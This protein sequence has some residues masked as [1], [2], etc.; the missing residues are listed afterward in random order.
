VLNDYIRH[1]STFP[2]IML[3]TGG[4]HVDSRSG[5]ERS[6]SQ[7]GYRAEQYPW[8]QVKRENRAER[9][10]ERVAAQDLGALWAL[11][12]HHQQLQGKRSPRTLT[13]YKASARAYLSWAFRQSAGLLLA[14][15]PDTGSAYLRHLEAR[16]LAPASVNA[17]RAA[18]VA[19]YRALRWT[20]ATDADPYRDTRGVRDP[21]PR[22]E[23]RAPYTLSELRVLLDAGTPTERAMLLLMGLCGLRLS[24]TAALC[25]LDVDFNAGVLTVVN[26]KGGKRARV[27]VPPQ[28]AAVLQ[29]LGPSTG[30]VLGWKDPVTLRRRLKALCARTGVR[31]AGR[32]AHGLRHTAGTVMYARTRNLRAVAQHLRH[33]QLDTAAIYAEMD[34]SE[35]RGAF[36]GVSL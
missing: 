1:V 23:K 16:G 25:W 31:Y 14:P 4:K 7:G 6:V 2:L 27:V 36:L 17:H 21:T 22:A 10:R 5:G 8:A 24:E 26:G 11:L 12:R 33:A 3:I 18:V 29:A 9:L 30:L 28:V 20:T 34:D 32:A 13:A 19:L 35:V 15:D